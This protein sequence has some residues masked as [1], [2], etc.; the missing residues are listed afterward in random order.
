VQDAPPVPSLD[1]ASSLTPRETEVL[2]DI[3]RGFSD[4]EIADRK[5]R[6][7][8]TVRAQVRSIYRKLGT[9]RR[10]ILAV[11]ALRANLLSRLPEADQR[12]LTAPPPWVRVSAPANRRT[13][14]SKRA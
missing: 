13:G 9:N 5:H 7:L 4:Q 1:L 6:S 8:L 11:F 3:G 10:T 2:R 14:P 12:V